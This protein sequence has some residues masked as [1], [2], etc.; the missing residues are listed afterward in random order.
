MWPWSRRTDGIIARLDK[1]VALLEDIRDNTSDEIV[2]RNGDGQ[3]GIYT[4]RTLLRGLRVD[5]IEE[6]P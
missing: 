4:P 6:E 3:L 5:D 2:A 1:L